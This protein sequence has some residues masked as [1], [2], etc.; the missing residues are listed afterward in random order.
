MVNLMVRKG[1]SKGAKVYALETSKYDFAFSADDFNNPQITQENCTP[2]QFLDWLKKAVNQSKVNGFKQNSDEHKVLI[3]LGDD[4]KNA[5]NFDFLQSYISTLISKSD[6]AETLYLNEGSNSIA[7][8]LFACQN[9]I[10]ATEGSKKSYLL[11][12]IEANEDLNNSA[13]AI[14]TLKS[15]DFVISLSSFN[16]SNAEDYCDVILPLSTSFESGG[17]HVNLL[18]QIQSFKPAVSCAGESKPAWKV[19]TVLEQFL[20]SSNHQEA[21]PIEYYNLDELQKVVKDTLKEKLKTNNSQPKNSYSSDDYQVNDDIIY[22]ANK[23]LSQ[24]SGTV[25]RAKSI[26]KTNWAIKDKLIRLNSKTA[27]K[28]N[29]IEAKAEIFYHNEPFGFCDL[30]IDN[31]VCDN[32]VILPFA[33]APVNYSFAKEKIV[34]LNNYFEKDKLEIKQGSA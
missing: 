34:V 24:K 11:I 5:P 6:K 12:D 21:K 2:H 27:K 1:V 3:I 18:N 25:R 28:L 17:V 9:H 16:N 14:K 32:L 8:N 31:Q 7:S 20:L 10:N 19:L 4:A 33:I 26:Q 30:I 23:G 13:K 15:A 29:L 22:L